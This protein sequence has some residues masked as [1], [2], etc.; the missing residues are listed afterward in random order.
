MIGRREF[1]SLLGGAAVVWPLAAR[2]Q[3][4][5]MPV[6]GF[7]YSQSP[8]GS[9]ESLRGFRQG[10][11]DAGFLEGDNVTIEYSW[12]EN[13]TDLLPALAAEL[14]RRRV[15][16]IAAMDS[17]SAPPAKCCSAALSSNI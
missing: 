9:T 1:V 4:P 17:N 8:E 16:V 7:L 12:A 10:L 15:A 11:K 2:A 3:Q 14:V 6:I 5:T 13:Q